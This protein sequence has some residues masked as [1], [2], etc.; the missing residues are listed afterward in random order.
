MSAIDNHSVQFPT[1]TSNVDFDVIAFSDI[2]GSMTSNFE[3]KDIFYQKGFV[4]VGSVGGAD[5]RSQ[6]DVSVSDLSGLFQLNVPLFDPAI[7]SSAVD[8]DKV[9]YLTTT[10]FP[11]ISF[12]NA[13]VDASYAIF[14]SHSDQSIKKDFLRSMLKDITGTTRLN[15]LFK[16][17]NTMISHIQN[18]DASFNAEIN[19]VLTS[20][21]SA[22]WLTDDDYSATYD[23]TNQTYSMNSIFDPY[24][25]DASMNADISGDWN[26]HYTS[27]FSRFNP[28]RILS[29]SIMGENDADGASNGDISG[30]GLNN[31]ARRSL[32]LDDLVADVSAAWNG[33]F[34]TTTYMAVH[35]NGS[36]YKVAVTAAAA[37]AGMTEMDGSNFSSLL[38]NYTVYATTTGASAPTSS[39][40]LIHNVVDKGYNLKFID[41][42]KLHLLLTYKP[43][44][45]TYSLLSSNPPVN[46][47]SYEVILNLK[48]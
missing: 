23:S 11:D 45:T 48:N 21:N 17:Q 24:S 44:A 36:N 37:E 38:S 3:F 47:R 32:L 5:A 13:E 15:N 27:A 9:R 33:E 16:N 2:S 46:S 22:G 34:S 18:L 40:G 10:N 14:S 29:S 12:S 39:D 26:A 4:D 8:T 6:I 31:E 19:N 43:L 30:T 42:D 1:D 41:G 35:T 28:L 20:I 7:G 25:F